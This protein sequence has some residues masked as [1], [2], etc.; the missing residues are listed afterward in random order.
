MCV[1]NYEIFTECEYRNIPGVRNK[2]GKAKKHGKCVSEITKD[3]QNVSREIFL[4]L[5]IKMERRTNMGN[6][7]QKLRKI[8]R[9]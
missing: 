7:C 5:E 4:Q 9:M 2:N 8:Y 3:L 6:V 1:R